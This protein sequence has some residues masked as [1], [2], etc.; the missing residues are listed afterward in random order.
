MRKIRYSAAMSLDGYIAGP[1][2]EFDWIPMDPDI[3]FGA[4]FSRFDAVLLG[5]KTFEAARK[6]GGGPS[7]GMEAFVFSRTLKPQDC[8]G[9]T[10][11]AEGARDLLAALKAKTGKDIWLMGGGSLVSSLLEIGMVDTVEVAVIP[12][13]LGRGI[14]LLAPLAKRVRLELTRS[15]VYEKTGT[16]LL[17][18]AVS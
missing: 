6:Q 9:A 14:P 8:P 11:V 18:Y 17:E 12:V 2:G 4:L 5:R 1:K 7:R 3:D 16:A 10:L 15:R 13:F